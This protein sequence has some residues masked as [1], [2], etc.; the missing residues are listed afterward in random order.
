M[1]SK[2]YVRPLISLTNDP[3]TSSAREAVTDDVEMCV[4]L[5]V[6]TPQTEGGIRDVVDKQDVRRSSGTLSTFYCGSIML[7]SQTMD[8][9]TS[10]IN[11]EA[12]KR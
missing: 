9:L 3:T 5:S 7:L 8:V 6:N 10:R 11:V 2:I 4:T 12:S 1:P